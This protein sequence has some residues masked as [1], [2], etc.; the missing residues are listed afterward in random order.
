MQY[1]I[2]K[3]IYEIG[4]GPPYTWKNPFHKRI[5]EEIIGADNPIL[6]SIPDSV[7]SA[8]ATPQSLPAI[9]RHLGIDEEFSNGEFSNGATFDGTDGTLNVH[10]VQIEN[11]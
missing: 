5:C 6:G 7:A 2:L 4:G 3:E 8:T 10:L 11:G 1:I 9:V